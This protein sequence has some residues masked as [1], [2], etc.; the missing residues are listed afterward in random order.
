MSTAPRGA[1]AV[2]ISTVADDGRAMYVVDKSVDV[3]DGELTPC[4]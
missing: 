4:G 2:H 3:E 1:D